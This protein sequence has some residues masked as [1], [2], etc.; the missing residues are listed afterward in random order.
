MARCKGCGAEI[1]WIKTAGGKSI[2]CDPALVRY[3]EAPGAKGKIVTAGGTVVSAELNV[4][5]DE[6]TGIGHISHWATCPVAN[7]FRRKP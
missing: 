1:L 7:K 2:P 4:P 3:K 5:A 6:A